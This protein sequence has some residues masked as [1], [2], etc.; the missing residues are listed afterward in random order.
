MTAAD[1]AKF[2]EQNIGFGPDTIPE[3]WNIIDIDDNSIIYYNAVN[4]T[5]NI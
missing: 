1:A 2:K 5:W 4:N 3:G